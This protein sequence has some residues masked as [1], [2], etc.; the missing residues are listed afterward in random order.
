[1]SG[2]DATSQME[3]GGERG[4]EGLHETRLFGKSNV[5]VGG[6][7]SEDVVRGDPTPWELRPNGRARV[8]ERERSDGSDGGPLR[9]RGWARSCRAGSDGSDDHPLRHDDA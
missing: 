4:V 7:A 9:M 1:M 5:C 3:M 2:G 8:R 6:W